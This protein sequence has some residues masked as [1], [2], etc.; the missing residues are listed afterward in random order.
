VKTGTD[1]RLSQGDGGSQSL[2]ESQAAQNR[3]AQG[4]NERKGEWYVCW[5]VEPLRDVR[6]TRKTIFNSLLKAAFAVITPQDLDESAQAG[7][8][9]RIVELGVNGQEILGHA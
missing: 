4:R 8:S 1:T 6:T 7:L 5:Y 9:D 2:T 3:F